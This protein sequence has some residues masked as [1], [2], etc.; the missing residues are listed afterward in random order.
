MQ[1]H[2]QKIIKRAYLR[3]RPHL[4]KILQPALPVSQVK[5][6][7]A[8]LTVD[9]RDNEAELHLWVNGTPPAPFCTELMSQIVAGQKA[10][11]LDI[12]ANFGLFSAALGKSVGEASRIVAF[13]PNPIM[14]GRL[15]KNIQN[16]GLSHIVRVESVAL[17]SGD[18][19]AE[20]ALGDDLGHSTLAPDH[21][22][23]KSCIIVPTRALRP[24][25]ARL[26]DYEVSLMKVDVEGAEPMVLGPWLIHGDK[27]ERPDFVL[28]ETRHAKSWSSDLLANIERFGYD[29]IFQ[30]EGN[31]LFQRDTASVRIE[32][33]ETPEA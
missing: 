1:L 27:Y 7:G 21:R 4:R 13:E 25:L 18:G 24:Y 2:E 31:A 16:N 33:E 29:L 11:V 23:Q 9:P 6:G 15:G 3:A 22:S 32:L 8:D 17:S 10:L 20:L 12:G 28:L 26:K 14:V 19:E 30:G 5:W